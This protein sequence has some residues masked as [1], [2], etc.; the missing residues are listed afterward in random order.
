MS[1]HIEIDQIMNLSG[2]PEEDIPTGDVAT[3]STPSQE[4]MPVV[5]S[6]QSKSHYDVA[7]SLGVFINVVTIMKNQFYLD[8][9]NR[10]AVKENM[11]F[12]DDTL[13]EFARELD[14]KGFGK[15]VLLGDFKNRRFMGM[16]VQWC[17]EHGYFVLFPFSMNCSLDMFVDKQVVMYSH[18]TIC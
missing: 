16:A 4:Y 14:E 5:K 17:L 7:R 6:F 11:Q 10:T 18:Q 1:D 13:T 2:L 15:T 12:D 3:W 8:I 9:A